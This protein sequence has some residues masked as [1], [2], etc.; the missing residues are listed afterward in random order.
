MFVQ[1]PTRA[2]VG[3]VG[4]LLLITATAEGLAH[5]TSSQQPDCETSR[6]LSHS[7]SSIIRVQP[8]D[9]L[10]AVHYHSIKGSVLHTFVNCTV[11]ASHRL[12]LESTAKSRPV[13]AFSISKVIVTN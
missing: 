11:Y 6:L 3:D 7:S 12:V 5:G 13:I 10:K 9:I 8:L 2:Q 1:L 4:D